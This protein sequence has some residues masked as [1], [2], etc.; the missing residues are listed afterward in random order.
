MSPGLLRRLSRQS[1][2]RP[3]RPSTKR[4]EAMSTPEA[5]SNG[6]LVSTV[7]DGHLTAENLSLEIGDASFVYR[8]FGNEQTAAPAL[9]MLQHFRGNSTTGTRR[10]STAS[11]RIERSS[12]STT[13]VSAVQPASSQRTSRAWLATRSRSSTPSGWSRSI[14]WGS[15][16]AASSP[17]SSCSCDRDSS[18]ASCS[19]ARRRRAAA[20]YTAGATR[21]T[22]WRQRTSPPPSTC[23]ACSSPAPRKVGQGNGVARTPLPTRGRP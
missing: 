11:R 16:S 21:C 2:T 13:A 5:L 1:A 19:P 22:R 10:S 9:V 7:Q 4:K 20:T 3:S 8:R 12:S 14:C 15:R 6:S 18:V 23:S 17:R